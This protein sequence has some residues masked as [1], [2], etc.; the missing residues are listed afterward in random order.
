MLPCSCL[1]LCL[2]GCLACLWSAL[3]PVVSNAV[4]LA[5]DIDQFFGRLASWI[6]RH[7]HVETPKQFVKV[8]QTFLDTL[9]G[10]PW[11]AKQHRQALSLGKLHDWATWVAGLP[12][13]LRGHT[14]PSAPHT[15]SFLARM[16][17]KGGQGLVEHP[18]STEA[19]T[20]RPM[21]TVLF[22]KH[23]M[24][25][26]TWSQPPF[27]AL[28]A[29][30]LDSMEPLPLVSDCYRSMTP[31][32]I[33]EVRKYAALMRQPPHNLIDAADH[34]VAWVHGDVHAAA[35]AENLDIL[36]VRA[37]V[38]LAAALQPAA[39]AGESDALVMD[40]SPGVVSLSARPGVAQPAAE[41]F[42]DQRCA[43]VYTCAAA[44]LEAQ[45]I[46]V[47][48]AMALG[49]RCWERLSAVGHVAGPQAVANNLRAAS[50]FAAPLAPAPSVIDA[51]DIMEEG[52]L[53]VEER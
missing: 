9:T 8:I 13:T 51:D 21:D 53:D 15:F 11:P 20:Q 33:G 47:A 17:V 38:P 45:G 29:I 28:P 24:S 41:G 1:V 22:L 39:S 40:P 19:K 44:A 42:T 34:L 48:A 50:A 23:W 7:H 4:S 31:K 5:Q 6:S 2:R 10:K 27:V 16:D 26:P 30:S 37:D 49:E 32:Y 12:T 36:R 25:S 18:C 46:S 3:R 43:V 35:T 52:P 14:G